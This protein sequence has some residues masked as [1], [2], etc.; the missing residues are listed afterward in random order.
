[1]SRIIYL[2]KHVLPVISVIRAIGEGRYP[3][4]FIT[5]FAIAIVSLMTRPVIPFIRSQRRP[6]DIIFYENF[7]YFHSNQSCS[8]L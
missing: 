8:K 7:K 4:I 1:M 2:E 6:I 5:T 3:P